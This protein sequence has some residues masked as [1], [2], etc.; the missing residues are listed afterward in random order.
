MFDLKD[1]IIF[2][3]DNWH[4]LTKLIGFSSLW[5]SENNSFVYVQYESKF[6][7]NR[8]QWHKGLGIYEVELQELVSNFVY[9]ILRIK[10]QNGDLMIDFDSGEAFYTFWYVDKIFNDFYVEACFLLKRTA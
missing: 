4:E 2:L 7:L 8:V 3:L 9:S 6:R 1:Q 10:I 5:S